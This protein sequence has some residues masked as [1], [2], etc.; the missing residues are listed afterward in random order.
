L[1]V[2]VTSVTGSGNLGAWPNAGGQTGLDAGDAICQAR[3]TAAGLPGTF[4]AWLSD[5]N[6]DAYCRLHNLTGQK[7]SYCGQTILPASAGPWVRT[8]GFPF[9]TTIDGLVNKGEIYSPIRFDEYGNAVTTYIFNFANTT[10]DGVYDTY[11]DY[12]SNAPCNGWTSAA[13]DDVGGGDANATTYTWT[14][15]GNNCSS[16]SPLFCFQTV[17]GPSLPTFKSAGKNVFVT[18]ISGIGNL[19][20]WE[21][22][23][24]Q[25]GLAAGDA[26]CQARA[27]AGGLTGSYKAWLSTDS[28]NAKGRFTSN[29]PWVRLDGVKIA[30]SKADL[31]DG[32]LFTSINIDELG[33]YTS[34]AAW[35]GTNSDG[36]MFAQHCNNWTDGTDSFSALGGRTSDAGG[37]WTSAWSS[38]PCKFNYSLYCFED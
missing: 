34:Y 15:Y 33:E 20:A 2:F 35:T 3:A 16:T 30:G 24:G 4:R 9:S 8:D 14:E 31:T 37:A 38:V 27:A 12:L 28:Q 25:T 23:G 36:T 32:S 17:N 26:I 19:G 18:S 21:D 29:G 7:A 13:V 1:K 22:A 11:Y 10:P 6:N 5:K